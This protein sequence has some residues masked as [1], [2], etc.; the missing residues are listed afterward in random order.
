M[1]SNAVASLPLNSKVAVRPPRPAK[2]E[3]ISIHAVP[4]APII[5]EGLNGE[6]A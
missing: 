1:E 6:D 4:G 3:L 2:V 5:N